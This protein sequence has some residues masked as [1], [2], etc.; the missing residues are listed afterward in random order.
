MNRTVCEEAFSLNRDNDP[1][2]GNFSWR[3]GDTIL[4]FVPE[5]P[6]AAGSSYSVK[7]NA[8]AEDIYGNSLAAPFD[9]E[10]T[11]AEELIPP[12][13]LTHEPRDGEQG[14]SRRQTIR[15]VFS[16]P[17]DRASLYT[18]FSLLPSVYGG[19]LW[20]Q[21]GAEVHFLPLEDYQPGQTYEVVLS[22]ELA[23]RS[24]NRLEQS[25]SFSFQ[26]LDVQEPSIISLQTSDDGQV[27]VSLE[28][29]GSLDPSLEIEKDETFLLTFSQ[30]LTVEQKIDLVEVD[31]ATRYSLTWDDRSCTLVF[32]EPLLWSQVYR[33]EVLGQTYTFLINGP[34]SVP[35]TVEGISYCPDLSAPYGPD[36]FV[37][38]QFAGNYDFSDAVAPAFD[39]HLRHAVGRRVDIGSF[40]VALDIS[41]V[42]DCL[43]LT[44]TDIELSPLA[45][46]PYPLPAEGQSVVRLFCTL[47]EDTGI[48]GTV[49]F[50]L[51]GSLRDDGDNYLSEDFVLLINNN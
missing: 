32:T 46:D 22:D 4:V 49:T 20:F 6:V 47:I 41:V 30:P 8:G 9:F 28:D 21:E 5:L 13:L 16:E 45:V 2:G 19:F 29:G 35:I 24:G 31:P 27:L 36:K 37:P 50:R 42:P 33:L 15:L 34:G 10:F 40:L 1:V 26:V 23:D 25:V 18:G 39:F 48:T 51:D 7:I 43:S 11:T 3:S 44:P 38:L 17:V 14:I 12:E